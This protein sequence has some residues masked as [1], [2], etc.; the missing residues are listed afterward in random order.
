V[1]VGVIHEQQRH[2][3]I[4]FQYYVAPFSADGLKIGI[5]DL[6]MPSPVV[7]AVLRQNVF[8]TILKTD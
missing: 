3:P 5:L 1:W 8:R 6:I 4:G 7:I 2:I